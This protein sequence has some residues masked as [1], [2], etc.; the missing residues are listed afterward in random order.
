MLTFLKDERKRSTARKC[1]A[2]SF[3][4]ITFFL[5]SSSGPLWTPISVHH[6]PPSTD[7]CRSTW[8]PQLWTLH[9]TPH[10]SR[11]P[12]LLLLHYINLMSRLELFLAILQKCNRRRWCIQ[13]H[14]D[15]SITPHLFTMKQSEINDDTCIK[16][17]RKK[18]RTQSTRIASNRPIPKGKVSLCVLWPL[19]LALPLALPLPP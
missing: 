1:I 8:Q 9:L 14:R 7:M 13:W 3:L 12:L 16:N 10:L 11:P 6:G 17:Q 19:T 15:T 18:S 2:K 5:I 4:A